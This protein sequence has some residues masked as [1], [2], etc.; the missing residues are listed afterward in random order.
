[1]SGSLE[2][3]PAGTVATGS[4]ETAVAGLQSFEVMILDRLAA[5]GLPT[6]GILVDLG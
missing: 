6:E 5:A 4:P 2:P 3:R 1:M